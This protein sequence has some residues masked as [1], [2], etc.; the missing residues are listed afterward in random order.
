[1]YN[2]YGK[3][4]RA[5]DIAT[6]ELAQ[7]VVEIE[8]EEGYEPLQET[9]ESVI[10]QFLQGFRVDWTHADIKK[11]SDNSKIKELAEITAQNIYDDVLRAWMATE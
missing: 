8:S 11:L 4:F 5:K 10:V 9:Q 2:K 1:M 6:V 3:A 7:I